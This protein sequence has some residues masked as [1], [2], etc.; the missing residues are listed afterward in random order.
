MNR[1]FK[2]SCLS[3]G[4][5]LFL[6]NTSLTGCKKIQVY[7]PSNSG[8]SGVGSSASGLA[9]APSSSPSPQAGESQE[10][11]NVQ[12]ETVL[13]G[14]SP[15]FDPFTVGLEGSP[16]GVGRI[17]GPGATGGRCRAPI[18]VPMVSCP[19]C[20]PGETSGGLIILGH[21]AA[22]RPATAQESVNETITFDFLAGVLTITRDPASGWTLTVTSTTFTV[23][24]GVVTLRFTFRRE[25]SQ[26]IITNAEFISS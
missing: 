19:S 14:G 1:F 6:I 21:G 9:A 22:C 11:E 5:I 3:L 15:D 4:V 23:T 12:L 20:V 26:I 7:L 16:Y 17:F 13:P 2:A 18:I 10:A 25:S 8:G 24:D